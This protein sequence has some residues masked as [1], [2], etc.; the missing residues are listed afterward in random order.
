MLKKFYLQFILLL[1]VSAFSIAALAEEEFL[2]PEEAF[3]IQAGKI[4]DDG[5][6]II[7]NWKIADGYYIYRD[8]VS[9]SSKND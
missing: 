3:A 2:P 6:A 7:V 4:S 1:C 9:F 8:K 5:Q